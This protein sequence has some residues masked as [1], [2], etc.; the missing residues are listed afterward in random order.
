MCEIGEGITFVVVTCHMLSVCRG[1]TDTLMWIYTQYNAITVL[2][3]GL[4]AMYAGVRCTN[5]RTYVHT[6]YQ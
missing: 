2:L 6:C 4:C 1:N 5:V 3:F